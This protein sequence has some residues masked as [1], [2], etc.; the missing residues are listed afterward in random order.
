MEK[1]EEVTLESLAKGVEQTT[2][3]ITKL[4]DD[5]SKEIKAKGESSAKTA[6]ALSKATDDLEQLNA[7]FKGLKGA[8][9]KDGDLT[10]IASFLEGG[11]E[12]IKELERLTKRPGWA[13]GGGEAQAKSPGQRFIEMLQA[14]DGDELKR[15]KATSRKWNSEAINF[16][17]LDP[18][19]AH[20]G[21]DV[22]ALTT[23]TFFGSG[24]GTVIQP[25]RLPLLGA[26][27]RGLV[28]RDLMNV[29]PTDSNAV[30]WI[31]EVGFSA[32]GA[33]VAVTSVTRS[34]ST[35]TVTTT[36]AHGFTSGTVIR[37]AG[38]NQAEYN[39][40]VRITVTSDTTF[41]YS[42]LGTPVTPATGTVTAKD[43]QTHGAAAP[44][45]EG[46]LK[47]E[48]EIEFILRQETVRTIPHWLPASRQ[49]LDD[50]PGLRAMID[51]RLLYG[52]SRAEE[53]QILYGPG[54]GNSLQGILTHPRRQVRSWSAGASGDT[55]IDAFRR[56]ITDSQVADYNPSGAV[57]NPVDWQEVE[58]TKGDDKHYIWVSVPEGGTNR[59]WKVPV[60]VTNAARQGDCVVGGFEQGSQLRDRQEAEI[61]FSE[62]HAEYFT[63]NMV[64]IL[65]EERILVTW[66]R[67]ES[68]VHLL[69]DAPP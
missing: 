44:T 66:I 10:K 17:S 51:N 37:I 46:T 24:S 49:I 32:A 13:A 40:D 34:G 64:A 67:P 47:P 62:H 15:L 69:L 22:K 48:A 36:A 52:L 41:T 56:A 58:L 68:F 1:K 27:E 39:G 42:I 16:K 63:S 45:A 26:K 50:L 43:L 23:G 38:A 3:H 14:N 8:L 11:D 19:V 31:E 6:E 20:A 12:R 60:V 25:E 4:L 21:A 65:A 28:I 57:M 54:S 59:L 55:R 29:A 5:Q 18:R 53:V 9:A 61:R 30:E 33:A 7:D 35:V 2:E